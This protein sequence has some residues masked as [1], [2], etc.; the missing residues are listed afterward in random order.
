MGIYVQYIYI[1]KKIVVLASEPV[2]GR[3]RATELPCYIFMADL[4]LFICFM[5]DLSISECFTAALDII[6]MFH[7]SSGL[8]LYVSQLI[9]IFYLFQGWILRGLWAFIIYVRADLDLS[10]CFR[11]DLDIICFRA[12]LD[13]ITV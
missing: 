4:D 11:A 5:A 10:I 9:W 2:G 12:D 7:S 1:Q 8:L 6:C 3:S 13:I